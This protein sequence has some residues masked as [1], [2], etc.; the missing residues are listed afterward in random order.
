M[1]KIVIL[2]DSQTSISAI[3]TL[4]ASGFDGEIVLFCSQGVLP[5]DGDLFAAW[6]AKDVKEAQ[7]HLKLDKFFEQNKVAV[8]AN[9]KLTRISTKR[10]QLTTENKTHVA[11]DKLLITDLPAVAYPAIKGCQKEGVYNTY[12][13]P[14]VKH[15]TKTL[16]EIDNAIVKVTCLEGFEFGCALSRAGKEVVMLAPKEG[17]LSSIFD[18]ETSMLLKQ[19]VEAKGIRVVYDDIDEVLGDT[20]VKAVKLESGKVM[21]AEGVIFDNVT[22]DLKILQETDLL[23]DGVFKVNEFHQTTIDGIFATGTALSGFGLIKDQLI[24]Q[25]KDAA[26][27]M[28]EPKHKLEMPQLIVRDFGTK[29]CDGFYG[30]ILRLPEGGKEHMKFD[31]PSNVYKKIYLDNDK[32]VGAVWMNATL[33]KPR[34]VKALQ[35]AQFLPAGQEEQFL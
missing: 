26:L 22:P 2:G 6:V 12:H 18:E 20:N 34:V 4:R 8:I 31:G 28:I 9:E 30:G 15:L 23:V 21:A 24:M 19:I 16:H 5:F 29:V 3:E 35:D 7:V 25:G 1:S 10:H 32:L 14:S 33:D 17:L 27:N 11:F 13:F